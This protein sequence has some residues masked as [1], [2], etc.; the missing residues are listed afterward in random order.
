MQLGLPLLSVFLTAASAAY[1]LVSQQIA[2]NPD[3]AEQYCSLYLCDDDLVANRGNDGLIKGSPESLR[4][5]R[6]ILADILIRD[7][8]HPQRWA[9]LCSAFEQSGSLDKA[10][11]CIDRALQLGSVSSDILLAAGNFFLSHDKKEEGLRC[12][13]RILDLTTERDDQVFSYFTARDVPVENVLED[14]LPSGKRTPQSYLRYLVRRQDLPAARKVWQS[15]TA[16]KFADPLM[17][18]DYTTYLVAQ[19]RWEEAAD[20]WASQMTPPPAGY[21]HTEFVYN[22]AF[23]TQP[24]LAPF[25]WNIAPADHAEVSRERD[26]G[27]WSLRIRFDGEANIDFSHIAQKTVLRPGAY[28]FQASVRTEEVTTDQ[29]IC[30]VITG[31]QQPHPILLEVEAP[32]GTSASHTVSGAFVAPAATGPVDIRVVRRPSWRF[33]NKVKGTVW[34]DRVSLLRTGF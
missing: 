24:L 31:T 32:R 33:D 3:R 8:A 5:A 15:I 23:K 22:G 16:R 13:S 26:A 19:S 34:I 2:V 27:K 25:D 20:A 30:F 7:P 6:Q 11:D 10:R 18:A 21:R 1:L 17:T 28:R 4:S 9:D 14:G 29:G 12:L